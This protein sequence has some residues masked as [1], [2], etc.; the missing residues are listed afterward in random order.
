[1]NSAYFFRRPKTSRPTRSIEILGLDEKLKDY[2]LRWERLEE[3]LR[4]DFTATQKEVISL[5]AFI[6]ASELRTFHEIEKLQKE[7]TVQA[8]EV[9]TCIKCLF[10]GVLTVG[11]VS[12]TVS[13]LW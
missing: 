12:I 3:V 9:M 5:K 7:L 2:H 6:K 13:L 10:Y 4:D 1:M 11:A 8:I